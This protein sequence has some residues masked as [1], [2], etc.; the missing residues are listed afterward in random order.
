MEIESK[1]LCETKLKIK[2]SKS[3]LKIHWNYYSR[4]S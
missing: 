3:E 4:S 1:I 2:W